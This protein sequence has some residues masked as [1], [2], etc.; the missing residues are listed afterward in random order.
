[1]NNLHPFPINMNTFVILAVLAT[2]C[3][4]EVSATGRCAPC[5][6]PCG[7]VCGPSCRVVK[8]GG[9]GYIGNRVTNRL[10][11]LLRLTYP[12]PCGCCGEPECGKCEARL[13]S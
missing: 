7:G 10:G 9:S 5:G 3:F 13:L 6:S 1:M 2:L 4:L 8:Q 11:D 12:E